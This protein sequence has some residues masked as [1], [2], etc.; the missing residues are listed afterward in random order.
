MANTTAIYKRSNGTKVSVNT[1]NENH[2]QA[3]LTNYVNGNNPRGRKTTWMNS[4]GKRVRISEMP[5]QYLRNALASIVT[6]AGNLTSKNRNYPTPSYITSV[7][8]AVG[9]TSTKTSSSRT[10]STTSGKTPTT[11]RSR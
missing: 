9:T 2:I 1:M 3:V 10:S 7:Q 4:D 11:K 8:Q 5:V 6:P